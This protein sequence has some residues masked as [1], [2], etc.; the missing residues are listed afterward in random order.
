MRPDEADFG[1][2]TDRPGAALV[3]RTGEVAHELIDGLHPRR[4]SADGCG[5]TPMRPHIVRPFRAIS[6]EVA[7]AGLGFYPPVVGYR[8]AA[9][10]LQRAVASCLRSQTRRL[11]R[12]FFSSVLIH[13][14]HQLRRT[15]V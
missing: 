7:A 9:A 11:P 15:L 8:L 5:M 1:T 13:H 12:L 14:I 2:L 10:T 6:A 3:C 4:S